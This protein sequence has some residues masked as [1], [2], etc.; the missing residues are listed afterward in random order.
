M[1]R[2]RDFFQKEDNNS[3]LYYIDT[4]L[5]ELALKEGNLSL[6]KKRLDEAVVPDFVEPNMVHIRNRYLQHYFEESK[7]YRR[8][9]YYLVENSRIDDS[10][11][12]ERIKM[13]TQEIAMKY[14]RDSILMKKEMLIQQAENKVL[15]LNQWLYGGGI[16]LLVFMLIAGAWIAY[17]SRKR[18]K[19]E[20][21][22][23]N[24]MT[25]LRLKNIRNRISPHFIFNVLNREISSLKDRESNHRLY[26]LV[27]L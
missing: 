13:R 10:I 24:A 7:D 8:A 12:S 1:S 25:S 5:I 6:A 2:C 27:K 16:V 26:E 22:M 3:A 23:R 9:Y 18:D 4:Q 14:R 17:R 15:H 11:R 19:E 20:W 21:M